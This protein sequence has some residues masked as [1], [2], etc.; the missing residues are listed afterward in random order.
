MKQTMIATCGW[1][2]LRIQNQMPQQ[3]AN[4]MKLKNESQI[5]FALCL[6]DLH[7]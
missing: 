7:A 5:L 1:L 4:Q 6:K 2:H 3:I